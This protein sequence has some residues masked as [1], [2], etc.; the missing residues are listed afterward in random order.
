MSKNSIEM[1]KMVFYDQIGEMAHFTFFDDTNNIRNIIISKMIF[2]S[3]MT[4]KWN[5]QRFGP[6]NSIQLAFKSCLRKHG[7]NVSN[8]A[9]WFETEANRLIELDARSGSK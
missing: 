3:M 1:F 8:W 5:E 6:L 4:N 9:E 2:T 7:Q